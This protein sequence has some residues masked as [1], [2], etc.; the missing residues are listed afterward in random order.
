M[1]CRRTQTVEAADVDG[2]WWQCRIAPMHELEGVCL[3]TIICTDVTE[4]RK[5]ELAL[6][7]REQRYGQLLAAV[8]N[9][10]Y[11]VQLE[12]GAPASTD[13]SWGCLSVTGYTP[14]DYKSDPFL[15]I[16]MVHPDDQE[17]VRKYVARVLAGET[18]PPIEHRIVRRDGAIRWLRD[19]VVPHR[20][21][22]QLIRYDGLVEDITERWRAEQAVRETEVQL[23]TA[24]KI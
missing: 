18:V 12:N 20:D 13:H 7:E 22:E 8:T 24:A 23:L 19:T 1:A 10:T 11:S 3:A 15:W 6:G 17:A 9:Y 21:G 14:D 5:V 2:H 16:K 4:Q